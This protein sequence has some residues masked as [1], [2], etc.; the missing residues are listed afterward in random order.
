MAWSA[1]PPSEA[2][3]AME[4]LGM[5]ISTHGSRQLTRELI[6]GADL[7]LGMTRQHTGRVTAL[8][9]DAAPRT[10][11]VGELVR[12][13]TRVGGRQ[14]DEPVRAWLARVHEARSELP[15][16]GRGEDEIGDPFG[17]VA[18][19]YRATAARLDRALRDLAELLASHS[20]T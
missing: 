12:I 20:R 6:E 17:E 1:G 3:A 14:T 2:I 4:E 9:P 13:G 5:D 7:V 11:L 16:P 19:V 10:Y 15:M 8:V 18:D